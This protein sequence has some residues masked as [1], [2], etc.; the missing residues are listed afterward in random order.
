MPLDSHPIFDSTAE[1]WWKW[2]QEQKDEV[3]NQ[4]RGETF[5][6]VKAV[7]EWMSSRKQE[8]KDKAL[9]LR[10]RGCGRWRSIY[11]TY[12]KLHHKRKRLTL[13][14]DYR[15][16]YGPDAPPAGEVEEQS[17]LNQVPA[18]EAFEYGGEKRSIQ[19]RLLVE[20]YLDEKHP[21]WIEGEVPHE[22][23]NRLSNKHNVSV[24]SIEKDILS[25]RGVHKSM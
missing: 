10:Y 4:Y 14:L 5:T 24:P 15:S 11:V 1:E 8:V 3:W 17:I 25:I 18:K 13:L 19:R 22:V 23:K 6:E 7:V 16:I 9:S 20:A 2:V 12:R 21:D